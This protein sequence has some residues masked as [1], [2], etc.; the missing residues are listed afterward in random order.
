MQKISVKTS[1]QS[2]NDDFCA[3]A[4]AQAGLRLSDLHD[5]AVVCIDGP[6]HR[7]SNSEIFHALVATTPLL[8]AAIKHCRVPYTMTPDSVG[9][10]EQFHALEQVYRALAKGD[11]HF[12][13]AAPLCLDREL[14][15][16]VMSW[17][18]GESV[19]KKMRRPTTFLNGTEWFSDIGAWLGTFHKAGPIRTQALRLDERL[20]VIDDL[21]ASA[22][23]H[24]SF[25][26]ALQLLQETAAPLQ[27]SATEVSWVHGDC[28]T[29]NF[30]IG[31]GRV[32]GIDMSII[33]E[34]S[35]EFDIAQFLN[36]LNLMLSGPRYVYLLSLRSKLE[37]AFW[38]GYR[39]TGPA[40][41]QAYLRWTRLLFATS[42]WH[43]MLR[44]KSPTI[45]N[46]L[47]NG[48]FRKLTERLTRELALTQ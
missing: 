3:I 35:V 46:R 47:L 28:K 22:L 45:R 32:Y 37:K 16:F 25:A 30:I 31:E 4:M 36:N 33:H 9:A 20:A 14:A 42:F 19:S 41:S 17:I 2:S 11:P 44:E 43:T 15:T 18:D 27:N 39:S 10:S 7:T 40:V 8:H 23:P 13:V 6:I 1:S 24:A 12:A 5:H 38:S 48:I 21:Y 34:N 26:R 29:D